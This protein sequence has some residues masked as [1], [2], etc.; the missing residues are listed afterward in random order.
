[1]H[2]CGN[3]GLRTP[4]CKV[5]YLISVSHVLLALQDYRYGRDQPLGYALHR[6]QQQQQ[7]D[8]Q[9]VAVQIRLHR[10]VRVDRFFFFVPFQDHGWCRHVATVL[11]AASRTLRDLE[12][13][14]NANSITPKRMC[15]HNM[16]RVLVPNRV[17][18]LFCLPKRKCTN[19]TRD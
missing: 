7:T 19:R 18:I 14:A 15:I 11:C 6:V 9:P 17:V 2:P 4:T 5:T 8:V 1:M 3:S 12:A 13:I 10:L 16:Y